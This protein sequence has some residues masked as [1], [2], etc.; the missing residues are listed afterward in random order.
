MSARPRLEL[1]AGTRRR[2]GRDHELLAARVLGLSL[3]A[4][5]ALAAAWWWFA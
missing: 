5:L 4:A 2:R 3:Y 1:E